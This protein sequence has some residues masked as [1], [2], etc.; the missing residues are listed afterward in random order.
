LLSYPIVEKGMGRFIEEN[1]G[2]YFPYFRV[3]D[4]VAGFALLM[5]AL[6]AAIAATIPAW[7]ASRLDVI[8]ALRRLG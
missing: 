8:D 4:E 2:A 3:P 5:A 7:R 1:M 6:L